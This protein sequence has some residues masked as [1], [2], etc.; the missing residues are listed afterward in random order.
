MQEMV[1]REATVDKPTGGTVLAAFAALAARSGIDTTPEQLCRSYSLVEP[2]PSTETLIALARDLGL[3]ARQIAVPWLD[4]PRLQ[5][6]LPAMIRLRDGSALLLVGVH[7][8]PTAGMIAVVR[9]PLTPPDATVG[10]DE[11]RLTALWDGEVILVK[12]RYAITDEERPFGLSWLV[13]QVLRERT[14]FIDI[15]AAAVV[16]TI[17]AV[18]PPLIFM[19]VINRVLLNHSLSTLNVIA[20]A[21]GGMIVFEMILGYLRRV[22][23]EIATTRIDARLNLYLFEKLVALPLEYFER[24]PTGRIMSKLGRVWQIRHFLTGQLFGV[25]LDAVPLVGLIPVMIWLDWRL[26]LF[27]FFL[28]GIIFVI[29]LSFIRPL[30][31][32]Y[33]RVV[34]AEQ[35]KGAHL[36]ES[37]YGMRTV[38]SLAIEGRRR[39]E[40]DRHV[41]GAAGARHA[42][43]LMSNYPDTLSLPFERLIYSGSFLLGSYVLVA[44]PTA[45]NPGVLI[46]FAMLSMRMAQPLIQCARMMQD[47][48]EARG[49]IAELATIMNELPEQTHFGTGLRTPILGEITFK[50]V[51]FRY[52]SGAPYALNAVTFAVGRGTIFGIMG[53]SG[54]GKST[55]TRLL[56]GL[57]TS[58]EGI[59][60]IDGMDLREIDLHHLRS[61]IGIVASETFLFSGSIRDNIAIAK[62][63]ASFA[64]VVRASQLAG[65]E[66]FIEQLPRGYDTFLEETAV[67]LSS[68]QRQRLAIARALLTDPAV[69]ILDEATSALDA[70]SEAI[71]NANLQRIASGRT[72]ICVSHRLS[73]LV[74]ADAIL[75]MDRGRVLDI[76]RHEDLLH[77]CEMY[78]QLWYQQNRHLTRG[79]G[80]AV[81]QLRATEA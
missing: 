33:H 37:I 13:G 30:G 71:I 14:L 2:E 79:S 62:P 75:V 25:F 23:M 80:N 61:S 65:A 38:K 53:R 29:V 60:K 17:F 49:A 59:I 68:G 39:Q 48:A 81:L 42:L 6:S 47:A 28:A 11:V 1:E 55:I 34:V 69:L 31:A 67:N 78:K 52:S 35:S 46:A 57:N 50:D 19:V 73:M 45:L 40:W 64:D 12:R 15:G 21:I 56:Q 54:S 44:Y 10:V 32:L 76:G 43:G 4:L 70:E 72:I 66:E 58:Y 36:V 22:L 27:V 41:A 51:R 63:S 18:A 5:G 7:T 3:E 26:A 8:E 77:R 20:V 74:P 16:S 9:D 24:N